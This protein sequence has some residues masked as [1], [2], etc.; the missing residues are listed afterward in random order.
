MSYTYGW[1]IAVVSVSSWM[2]NFLAFEKEQLVVVATC[3]QKLA[4][5]T[6]GDATDLLR[7]TS[8]SCQQCHASM[9][10]KEVPLILRWPFDGIIINVTQFVSN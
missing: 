1:T 9:P 6:P 7:M 2:Q 4:V 5:R 8:D 3:S 10:I